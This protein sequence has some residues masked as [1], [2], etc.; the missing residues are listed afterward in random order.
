MKVKV[1]GLTSYEDA[2]FALDEGVDALGFNFSRGARA[3]SS[4]RRL[5]P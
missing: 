1:C 3:T 5:G 2:V 4:L